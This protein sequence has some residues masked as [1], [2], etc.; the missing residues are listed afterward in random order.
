MKF[1]PGFCGFLLAMPLVSA[2]DVP[3]WT[4]IDSR[5][6]CREVMYKIVVNGALPLFCFEPK[7]PRDRSLPV[8]VLFHGG[9][10]APDQFFPLSRYLASRGMAAISA[11]YR[12]KPGK[13][14]QAECI[15]NAKSVLRWVRIHATELGIDP[16]RILAGGGSA[17][18]HLAACTVT[19][20]GFN[21]PG[22]NPDVSCKP[23]ALVLFN[24][25][26]DTTETGF[27]PLANVLRGLNLDPRD[28]SP[29][30]HIRSG[31]PPT[32]IFHGTADH[33]IPFEN[34][35]RVCRLMKDAGNSCE[36]VA[37]EGKDHGFFNFQEKKDDPNELFW[38][39]AEKIDR[40][41]VKLGCLKP[42]GKEN[43]PAGSKPAR[44]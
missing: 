8:L 32:L 5:V 16:D 43:S 1:L 27:A 4:E 2:Q 24:P 39:V 29:A 42:A 9:G 36:L 37:Y 38:D 34:S 3:S 20:E 33:T 26:L 28:F 19:L 22:E 7:A 25:L 41:L 13:T 21:E 6:T 40:F 12:L 15:R 31:L 11:E 14:T 18:G 35:E 10:G 44:E 23:S 30:H 17:G